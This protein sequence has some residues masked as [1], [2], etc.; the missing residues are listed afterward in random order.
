MVSK[1]VKKES[2]PQNVAI[3][4][5]TATGKSG[6]A[7]RLAERFGGEIISMDS[8][9][10]YLGLDIGT[11]KVP[12]AEQRGI[13]HHLFD[14]L[15]PEE[16]NSAGA[17]LARANEAAAGIRRRGRLPIFV[18]G[19]G[20]YFRALFRGLADLDLPRPELEETRRLFEHLDTQE[21]YK[22]LRHC[23]PDRAAELS[24]N[25]R[26]RISRSLEVVKI[27]GK[28]ISEHFAEQAPAESWAGPKWVLTA[29]REALR[30]RIDRRTREMYDSGWIDEVR[31]LLAGGLSIEAPAM[32]S[33]GYGEIA[34]AIQAGEDPNSTLE[35]VITITCQY[36]KRQE[37]FFRSEKDAI[38]FDVSAR[39]YGK[40]ITAALSALA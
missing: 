39:D 22:E 14:V 32:N 25:D 19:T 38:W 4:G 36:A 17:H 18:G 30:R 27:T 37:T 6:L 12:S 21:L 16:P 3:M 29:P 5:A 26:L 1:T 31:Q 40:N 13:T 9:Q 20:L 10:V 34:R 8:R 33:L 2:I 11:A 7:I 28:P 24:P 15:P 23:D 35:Q